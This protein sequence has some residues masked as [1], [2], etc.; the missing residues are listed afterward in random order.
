MRHVPLYYELDWEKPPIT[1]RLADSRG[2][3]PQDHKAEVVGYL[4]SGRLLVYAMSGAHDAFDP[5]DRYGNVSMSLVTDGHYC[6]PR[7]L[8]DYVERYDCW[9]TPSFERHM[10]RKRWRLPK[11]LMKRELTHYAPE[12]PTADILAD[13]AAELYAHD[14]FAEAELAFRRVVDAYPNHE[15]SLRSL[16]PLYL[17]RQRYHDAIYVL[18]C[19]IAVSPM[20]AGAWFQRGA[21]YHEVAQVGGL[22]DGADARGVREAALNDLQRAATLGN[23][24]AARMLQQEYGFAR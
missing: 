22:R 16:A 18:G 23:R 12:Q 2:K 4:R 1:L 7:G 3:R 15:R 13:L 10:Q 24:Q 9:L 8:A 11:D 6:W 17:K 21:A 5:A 20:D 14:R 19:L